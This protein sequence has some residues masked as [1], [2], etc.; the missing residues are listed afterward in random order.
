[1]RPRWAAPFAIVLAATA[2][3]LGQAAWNRSLVRREIVLSEREAPVAYAGREETALWL[4]WQ[5]AMPLDSGWGGWLGAAR[6]AELGADTSREAVRH[7]RMDAR[8]AFAVLELDG[9]AWRAYVEQQVLQREH[10]LAS[11]G[12]L[13]GRDSL[14]ALFRGGLEQGSRLIMIDAGVDPDALARRYPDGSRHL[15]LPAV[16][17]TYREYHFRS[18]SEPVDTALGARVDL[19]NQ[20][21]LVSGRL[22]SAF[23]PPPASGYRVTVA[24]GRSYAPWIVRVE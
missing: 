19:E 11:D 1:M 8:P 2:V 4:R 13:L 16:V 12:L 9:P 5:Y 21:V 6:L 3:A 20:R 10:E 7:E 18:P 14:L 22:A 15:I 17:R 23:R 24:T